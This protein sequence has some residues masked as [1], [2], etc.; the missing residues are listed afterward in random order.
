MEIVFDSSTLI[1]L[2]KIEILNIISEDIQ[3]IVPEMVR[4]E[5]TGKDLFDAK[6]ISSLIKNGK[7]KV[8]SVTKKGSAEK[9]CRDFKIHIGEAEALVLALKKRLPLAVDDLP[10]IKACKILNHKFTTA[11]H[12]LINVS[13]NRKINEDMTF[14]KLEKLSLYGRY[15][16]RILEDATKRL[17]GGE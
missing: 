5:C 2:A 9:L 12:F 8:A 10:S 11:I 17:K 15:S 1:L 6:L 4:S 14:V 13:E 3:I 16:K 7:I